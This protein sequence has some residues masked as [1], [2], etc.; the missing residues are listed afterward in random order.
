MPTAKRA[1]W[2]CTCVT[3]AFTNSHLAIRDTIP[4]PLSASATCP[5]KSK[6]AKA[7]HVSEPGI[8]GRTMSALWRE[9]R[10]QRDASV[11]IQRRLSFPFACISFAL[12]AMPIGARPR[13]G[14]RAAGF[15][16][17]LLLI[18]GYYLMFTIGAGL[19]RQGTDSHLGR[20]L[21][22]EY[23]YGGTGTVS[24]AAAGAHAR[25]QPDQRRF[26]LDCRLAHLEDFSREKSSRFRRPRTAR[27]LP[28]EFSPE[29]KAATGFLSFWTCICCAVFSIISCC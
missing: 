9:R 18:T 22:G 13:R 6:A 4:S 7:D 5:W 26:C 20:D 29:K 15:L 1:S 21:V 10:S 24:P 17:T 25:Q 11:E 28:E 23:N 3:E 16:I 19:A 8:P 27:P 2:S 12:L 14:G